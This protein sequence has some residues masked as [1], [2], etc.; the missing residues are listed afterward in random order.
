MVKQGTWTLRSRIVVAL[1]ALLLAATGCS[2]D[3]GSGGAGGGGTGGSGTGGV[4]ATATGGAGGTGGTASAGFVLGAGLFVPPDI[5]SYAGVTDSLGPDGELPLEETIEVPGISL[6]YVPGGT[7]EFFIDSISEL[8]LTKYT[9]E[10]GTIS[11]GDRLSFANLGFATSSRLSQNVFVSSTRAYLVDSST[12][13]IV[14]W[15]PEAMEIVGTEEIDGLLRDDGLPLVY[16]PVVRD[17][18]AFFPFAY[19][20]SPNDF[21]RPEAV[22]LVLDLETGDYRLIS[23]DT[24]GDGIYPMIDDSGDIYLASGVANAALEYLGR[25]GVGAAC[26]RRIRA[27]E[28]DFDP[29]FHPTFAEMSGGDVGGGIAQGPDGTAY[30]RLLNTDLIQGDPATSGAMLAAPIWDWSLLDLG[31]ETLSPTDIAASAGRFTVLSVD[32]RTFVTLSTADFS[33]TTL[34]EV[35]EDPPVAG[36]EVSGIAAGLGAL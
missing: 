13:Q 17:G 16:Q 32:G 31:S 12:L 3:G 11:Q 6:L 10:D 19:F 1:S 33:R 20:D 25:E 4:G 2:D 29:D 14:E 21:I 23:D 27:G 15:N 34:L 9:V 18:E 36:I 8:F 30:V 7:G 28:D 22:M 24:C 35:S 26:V 5:T